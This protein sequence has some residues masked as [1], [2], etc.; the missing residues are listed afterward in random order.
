M[1]ERGDWLTPHYNYQ[2]RWQKPVLYYWLAATMYILVGVSEWAARAWSALAGVGVAFATYAAGRRMTG[3]DEVGW[4]AGAIAAT[5]FGCFAMARLALQD[6]P[7][8][9]FITVTITAAFEGRWLL[10]G[11]ALG[12]GFLMKGPVALA[13]PGVVLLPA[14]WME[15]QTFRVSI[16]DLAKGFAVFALVGLPW[17]VAM[18]ATH[19]TEYLRSFFVSDNFERFAT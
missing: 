15:R 17:Y 3:H 19:G 13:V 2:Y 6:L 18:A 12:L 1:V 4:L 5:C 9:F 16:R 8:A 11:L 7:L 14:W 10:A